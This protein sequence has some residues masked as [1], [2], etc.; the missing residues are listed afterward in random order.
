MTSAV[1][2][3]MTTSET[4]LQAVHLVPPRVPVAGELVEEALGRSVTKV[5]H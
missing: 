3:H 4:F 2:L 1:S 5:V